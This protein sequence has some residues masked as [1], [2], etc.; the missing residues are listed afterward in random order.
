MPEE[1]TATVAATDRGPS[2]PRPRPVIPSG[3]MNVTADVPTDFRSSAERPGATG[4][5][6]RGCPRSRRGGASS[7]TSSRR[8]SQEGLGHPARQRLV[9]HR[10]APHDGRLR[11]S[12]CRS[13]STVAAPT[14]RCSSSRR[15]CP[16]SG[17]A[18]H[19]RL[20]SPPSPAR[21]ARPADPLPE[22]RAA[23]VARRSRIVNFPFGLI[24]LA[25]WCSSS[26][27]TAS[28]GSAPHPGRRGRPVRLH[29]R[30][31]IVL[32][33]VNVFYRDVGNVAGTPSGCRSTSRRRSTPS[34]SCTTPP[35][36]CRS[37]PILLLNPWVTLFSAYHDVIFFG[38]PPDWVALGEVLI[39]SIVLL[40]LATL[41]FKRLEPS[42]A[43]VL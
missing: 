12:S 38:V 18:P 6:A 32:A 4:L 28:R 5:F 34:T 31:T 25:R 9:G 21:N 17:S 7:A 11:R 16:G 3:P 33:A 24:P 1:R 36:R 13:S 30:V 41:L 15:S 27:A 42:F 14:T 37:S 35:R 40:A 2:Q 23:G 20:A 26:I 10:P 29:G 43:K 8:T 19:H 39:G 22:D